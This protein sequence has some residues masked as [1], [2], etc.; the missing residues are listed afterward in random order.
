MLIME[1]ISAWFPIPY[2]LIG[3]L[4]SIMWMKM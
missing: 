3:L 2:Q 1:V 4:L